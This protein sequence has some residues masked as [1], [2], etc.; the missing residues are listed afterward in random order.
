MNRKSAL[1][2]N[3][4]AVHMPSDDSDCIRWG[5]DETLEMVGLNPICTS[6]GLTETLK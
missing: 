3:R 5:P 2:G 4:I 6:S 1:V